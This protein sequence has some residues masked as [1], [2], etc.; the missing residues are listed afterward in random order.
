MTTIVKSIDIDAPAHAVW[1]KLSNT[2]SISDLIGF[3]TSSSQVGDTRVCQL[4][5]G[6]ELKEKIV[7][8]D[9]KLQRVMY[10]ITE[11]PLNMDFHAAS[12][13]L[14]DRGER[15]RLVWTVDVCPDDAA[16]NLDPLLDA[17]SDDLKSTLSS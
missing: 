11:S 5:G 1:P 13:Q 10:A 17:A 8:V 12:M 16:A 9:D 14:E 3:I 4:D 6:G 7:S 2:S 15:S